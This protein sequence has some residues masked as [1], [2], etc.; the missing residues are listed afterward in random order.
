MDP[1]TTPEGAPLS[2]EE[3][4][5]RLEEI[6]AKLGDGSAPLDESLALFEE[7]TSLVR[8]CSGKLDAAERRV[9]IL[10]HPGV[11]NAEGD[12]TAPPAS[13]PPANP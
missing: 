10:L 6:V 2:F 13:A 5:R 12:F 1:T 4:L 7:G 8:Y 9:K 3:A 11:D